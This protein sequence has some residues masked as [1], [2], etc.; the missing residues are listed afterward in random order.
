MDFF[1]LETDGDLNDE[2]LGIVK[3]S[4]E[5]LGLYDYKLAV[6]KKFGSE[7]PENVELQLDEDTPGMT[8]K[9]ILGNLRGY[10]LGSSA[11]VKVINDNF[12]ELEIETLPFK[13]L[14]Q[15]GRV[16]SEDYFF[17]NPLDHYDCLKDEECDISYD[18]DGSILS[19]RKI[20]LDKSKMDGAPDF[21]RVDKKP[22]QYVFSRKFGKTLQDEGVDNLLG[23]PL[24][25]V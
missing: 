6:G 2:S 10:F 13:L 14:D 16:M 15:K 20:I 5:A 1:L 12:P 18:D 25:I 17:I 11:V 8:L 23:I 24:K 9:A 21:F 7:Y 4:P 22:G 3:R 19:I